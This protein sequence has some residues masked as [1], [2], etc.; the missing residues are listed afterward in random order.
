MKFNPVT[1]RD[2]SAFPVSVGTSLALE[3]LFKPV[4]EPIDPER[5]IPQHV[6]L[7]DY[8]EL[9]IN[10]FTLYRNLMAA[11]TKEHTQSVSFREVAEGIVQEID[12]ITEIFNSYKTR[13]T[14]KIIFY[15]SDYKGIGDQNKFV[16]PRKIA[17]DTQIHFSELYVATA[18]L[19]IEHYR[20]Y[21]NFKL[22]KSEIKPDVRCKALIITHV[23][24][25]LVSY[26]NFREL[27]LL[28]SHTGIL[29]KYPTWHTKY[30]NGKELPDLPF[31]LLLLKIFGDANTY[32]PMDMRLRKEILA[33][34]KANRWTPVTSE[35]KV[36]RDLNQMKNQFFIDN[37]KTL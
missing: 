34:A 27:D 36:R 23:A 4:L 19:L 22:F 32:R 31:N 15:I 3:S 33:I 30:Y 35:S 10:V 14:Q 11:L 28:E 16:N 17:T 29:K 20:N 26:E 18:K 6:N 37:L 13:V 1:E 8:D 5:K 9:W 2:I 7:D 24:F 25:D 12:Y 21:S